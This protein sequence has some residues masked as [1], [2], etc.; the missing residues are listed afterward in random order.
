MASRLSESAAAGPSVVLPANPAYAATARLFVAS[1]AR[2]FGVHETDVDDARLAVSEVF[3]ASIA[4]LVSGSASPA[5]GSVRVAPAP[6]SVRV[7]LAPGPDGAVLLQMAVP[8]VL[9]GPDGE[10]DTRDEALEDGTAADTSI[11]L[12]RI[13][14]PD[15]TIEAGEDGGT[16]VAFTI[17]GAGG[18][19]PAE[20]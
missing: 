20:A 9:P 4:S 10:H 1:S 6:G 12:V 13:L 18:E 5:T 17:P 14:F 16:V 19:E 2:H 7:A 15:T 11:R 8:G 3:T